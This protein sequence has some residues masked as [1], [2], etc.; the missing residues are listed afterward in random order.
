MS[1][2]VG[3]KTRMP[4]PPQLLF[5]VVLEGLPSKVRRTERDKDLK[6]KNKLASDNMVESVGI[7]RESAD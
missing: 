5:N 2:E 4:A 7:W 1:F 3:N 6:R